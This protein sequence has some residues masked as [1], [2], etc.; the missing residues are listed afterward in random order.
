[1][2]LPTSSAWLRMIPATNFPVSSATSKRGIFVSGFRF[3]YRI[4]PSSDCNFRQ[5]SAWARIG[6]VLLLC[7]EQHRIRGSMHHSSIGSWVNCQS[8]EI[9]WKFFQWNEICR[10]R[11]TFCILCGLRL[12][13][14]HPAWRNV[15]GIFCSRMYSPTSA[16]P[17]KW[18]R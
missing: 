5:R 8:R 6:Y 17:S 11:L 15:A 16:L 4:L 7:Y 1:M 18:G 12:L 10:S 2:S 9:V 14:K 3:Q 13:M